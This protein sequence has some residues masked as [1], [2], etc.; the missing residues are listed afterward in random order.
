MRSRFV[1]LLAAAALIAGCSGFEG[2]RSTSSAPGQQTTIPT[3][4]IPTTLPHVK[5]TF[6]V[7]PGT[8]QIAVLGA[9]PGDSLAVNHRDQ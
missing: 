3:T 8:D 2:S 6:V 7:Q 4:T 1:K 9:Q 5:A